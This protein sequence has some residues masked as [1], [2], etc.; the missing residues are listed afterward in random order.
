MRRRE[1]LG[2]LGC[3]AA[4][5]IASK[6]QPTERTRVVGVLEILGPDDPE[7]KTRSAVFAQTLQELG[8]AVGRDLKIETRNVGGDLDHLRRYA[9]ELIA[10]APDVIV[11]V[12]SVTVAPLQQATRTIPIVFVNVPDPVGA[13]F[14]QS[15]AHP[16]G[17]ITGFLNFEYRAPRKIADLSYSCES[18]A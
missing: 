17:N 10:L 7:S 6:A 18:A 5:P 4:W 11:S 8:W 13:G 1:F 2:I 9:V 12:G 14:V 15:M 3:A 16:G